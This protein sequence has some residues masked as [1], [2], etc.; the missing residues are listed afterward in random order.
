MANEIK[1]ALEE[2]VEKEQEETPLSSRLKKLLAKKKNL[3]MSESGLSTIWTMTLCVFIV[4]YTTISIIMLM[5][6]RY[7]MQFLS[8]LSI[9]ISQRLLPTKK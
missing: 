4:G 3:Q 8:W 2:A 9:N 6:V 5:V 7:L 1:K